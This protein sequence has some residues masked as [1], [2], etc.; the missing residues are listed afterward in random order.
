MIHFF[1]LLT[2]LFRLAF[3]PYKSTVSCFGPSSSV[4]FPAGLWSRLII[5]A[6][7]LPCALSRPKI[8]SDG[9]SDSSLVYC[10]EYVC[11]FSLAYNWSITLL[12]LDALVGDR[13]LIAISSCCVNW[14][15]APYLFFQTSVTRYLSID[16][17]S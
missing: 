16:Y 15:S 12:T 7:P 13:C 10:L 5:Y 9:L 3:W 11:F 4:E 17:L 8:A 2:T 14:L 6:K 1:C